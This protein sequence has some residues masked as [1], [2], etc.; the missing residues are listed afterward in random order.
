MYFLN[1]GFGGLGGGSSPAPPPPPGCATVVLR[2][3]TKQV[4]V[5]VLQC[6]SII[7]LLRVS[8]YSLKIKINLNCI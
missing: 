8:R 4:A 6:S 3:V 7:L 1:F 2:S 5:C